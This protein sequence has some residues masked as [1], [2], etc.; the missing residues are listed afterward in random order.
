MQLTTC[1]LSGDGSDMMGAQRDVIDTSPEIKCSD[2][3]QGDE[4]QEDAKC[5]EGD[6][7]NS[8]FLHI[9]YGFIY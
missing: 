7:S 1:L 3:D 9:S 6:S 5:S 8:R 4:G 2:F